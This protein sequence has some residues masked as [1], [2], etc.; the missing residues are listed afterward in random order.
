MYVFVSSVNVSR[1]LHIKRCADQT[2]KNQEN[3]TQPL[4]GDTP[5]GQEMGVSDQ[6]RS[7]PC[8]RHGGDGS[9][10]L[11]SPTV[12]DKMGNSP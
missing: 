11:D 8:G 9:K 10:T 7:S 12:V 1:F 3:V 6:A 4:P 2:G 5:N